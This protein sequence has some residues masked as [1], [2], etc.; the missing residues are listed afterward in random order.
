MAWIYA[1]IAVGILSMLD[2]RGFN[3]RNIIAYG[4][5]GYLIYIVQQQAG[6]LKELG[7]RL[8]KLEQTP[9]K[10]EAIPSH[11]R[12]E[13]ADQTI[14]LRTPSNAASTSGTPA[15]ASPPEKAAEE[16][17]AVTTEPEP[18]RASTEA[19]TAAAPTPTPDSTSASTLSSGPTPAAKQPSTPT[20]TITPTTTPIPTQAPQIAPTREPSII[21]T[22]PVLLATYVKRYFT[23]GNLSVRVGI[24]ILFFGVSFLAKYSIDN[25]IIPIEIRLTA[26]ALGGIAMLAIGWRLRIK[27]PDYALIMQGGAIAVLY[28]TI[29]ASFKIYTLLP[30]ALVFPLLI[31]FSFLA[32][33]LAVLQDSRALAVAA[34]TGGFAAPILSSTGSG[35]HVA[36]FAYYTVLNL[37][38]F[39]VAWKKSWRLLNVVGFAFTFIISGFWGV[40]SY[41][42]EDFA[43]TEPFLLIYFAIYLCIAV[44]F[45]LKQPPKLK[46]YVDGSLVFGLP[47]VA[48]G[49]QAQLVADTEYGLAISTLFTGLIYLGLAKVLWQRTQLRALCEAFLAIGL[50]FSTLTIPFALSGEWTAASWAIEGAG[51]IW[52]GLRQQRKFAFYFGMLVQVAGGLIYL[53][54]SGSLNRHGGFLSSEYLSTLIVS[55]SAL[56]SAYILNMDKIKTSSK[57]PFDILFLIWALA[58]WYVGG[59]IK[60]EGYYQSHH[61]ELYMLFF[62]VS[63]LAFHIVHIKVRWQLLKFSPWL[64]LAPLP[65]FALSVAIEGPVDVVSAA[66]WL[67]AIGLCFAMLR[68]TFIFKQTILLEPLFH[69][70]SFLLGVFVAALLLNIAFDQTATLRAWHLALISSIFIAA[71]Y[72]INNYQRWPISAQ[73]D[74]YQKQAASVIG[75]ALLLFFLVNNIASYASPAPL[76]YIPLLNP[77]DIAQAIGLMVLFSWFQKFGHTWL[78][79]KSSAYLPIAAALGFVWFNS[80]LFKTLHVYTGV[81]YN[82]AALLSSATV[83]TAVSISWTLISLGVMIVASR[84]QSRHI[85]IAGACLAGLV[86]IKLFLFDLIERGTIE[87]I[88]SFLGVGI[89]LMVVG[90]FSPVPPN[91]ASP[92]DDSPDSDDVDTDKENAK[93]DGEANSHAN[94]HA[95]NNTPGS[96][97]E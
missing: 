15:P 89:L 88:V 71:L 63:A 36:L 91:A 21:E 58:W 43:S 67:L 19:Q 92:T 85:W 83:Q 50:I 87:R 3:L 12:A 2:T 41:Q 90:Y 74:S 26:I 81:Q 42:P 46:G 51:L 34:I 94:S 70:L 39:A 32:M 59:L 65:V 56:F 20:T 27:R 95:N 82:P 77:L 14:D 84:L 40:T 64:L 37:A 57:R 38:L 97:S 66:S 28:L 13:P 61:R 93:N 73:S 78:K 10:A 4:V 62:C 22:L 18:V 6:R 53:S 47:F 7:L 33:S 45:A 52:I 79:I 30:A 17:L 75:G 72:F 5:L 49:F 1:A 29:F 54:E 25:S 16:S 24:I 35:N 76:P 31:V 9:P 48:F 23:E 55:L 69:T 80:L 96:S 60:V 86:V 68:S 8:T 44:L 11:E